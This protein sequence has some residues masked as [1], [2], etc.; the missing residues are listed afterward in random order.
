MV[1]H[2]GAEKVRCVGYR[3]DGPNRAFH[4]RSVNDEGR[5]FLLDIAFKDW[6]RLRSTYIGASWRA[7]LGK[8]E[9]SE[10]DV[11]V[12]NM[13]RTLCDFM[14]VER[15]C[16]APEQ[17]RALADTLEHRDCK[18]PTETTFAHAIISVSVECPQ[19]VRD[20]YGFGSLIRDA[21]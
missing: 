13:D 6:A 17:S 20:R 5:A 2:P 19:G 10:M 18:G 7:K 21:S 12:A 4:A 1:R 16:N 15:Q 14:A 8:F 11:I 3:T 9:L